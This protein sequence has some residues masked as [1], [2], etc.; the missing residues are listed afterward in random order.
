MELGE[1]SEQHAADSAALDQAVVLARRYFSHG[2]AVFIERVLLG[3][4]PKADWKKLNRK[5][6]FKAKYHSRSGK[7]IKLLEQLLAQ[8]EDAKAE[9]EKKEKAAKAIFEKLHKSLQ[10]Q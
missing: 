1:N 6:T 2:D 3:E 7:I 10:E 4:V 8:F 9:G 5:A